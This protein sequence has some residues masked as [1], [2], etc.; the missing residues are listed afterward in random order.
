VL[1]IS[2]VDR[3]RTITLNRPEALNSFNEA[4][5]DAASEA[6]I[7]AATDRSVAV[8]VITSET[9]A[10]SPTGCMDSPDSWISW[11]SSPNR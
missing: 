6:L 5:Y 8:V 4:L 9:P 7:A 2:D 10:A 1:E 11:S 3:I